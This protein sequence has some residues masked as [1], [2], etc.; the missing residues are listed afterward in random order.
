MDLEI[1]RWVYYGELS[2]LEPD[3]T[4]HF[5]AGDLADPAS[6]TAAHKFRTAPLDQSFSFASGGDLGISPNAKT[7]LQIAASLEPLYISL[8]G[9][10][11]YANAM[12]PCY[13]RWDA[14]LDMYEKAAKTPSGYTVPI[15]TS[16]GNHEAGGFDQPLSHLPFYTRYFVQESLNGRL[17]QDLPTYNTKYIGNQLM[18]SLDSSVITSPEDQVSFI[19]AELSKAPPGTLKTAMYHA[20]GYPSIRSFTNSQSKSIRKHFVPTFDAYKLHVAFENHDHAYKRSKLLKGGVS[21]PTGTLYIGD[22]SMGATSRLPA[23]NQPI[24]ASRDYL[25]VLHG[26]NFVLFI[27]V[28]DSNYSISAIDNSNVIFD[29]VSHPIN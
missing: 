27:T 15:L 2:G 6:Y 22:G 12:K 24:P 7:L 23:G 14:W 28:T 11:A 21:D 25:E 17:P 1:K 10:L 9:D 16:V 13:P 19:S 20:P 18:L 4:Y 26:N 29:R 8:G 3:T 5:V